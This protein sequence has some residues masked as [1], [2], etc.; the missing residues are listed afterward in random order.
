MAEDIFNRWHE[1]G[2]K[3]ILRGRLSCSRQSVFTLHLY[4]AAALPPSWFER[5]R[6][7][8]IPDHGD[9]P[10]EA[11]VLGWSGTDETLVTAEI[12]LD[13]NRLR[14]LVSEDEARRLGDFTP[15]YTIQLSAGDFTHRIPNESSLRRFRERPPVQPDEPSDGGSSDPPDGG[16]RPESFDDPF[17]TL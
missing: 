2:L 14:R 1:T 10:F 15:F 9:Q 11:A 8:L 12:Q 3:R 13:M 16:K 7:Q 4:V 6:L 5:V 17:F